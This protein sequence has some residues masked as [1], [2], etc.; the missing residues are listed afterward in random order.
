M[1]KIFK[2]TISV[3]TVILCCLGISTSVSADE[4]ISG[5]DYKNLVALLENIDGLSDEDNCMHIDAGDGKKIG[6]VTFTDGKKEKL[7]QVE[8]KNDGTSDVEESFTTLDKYAGNG[9]VC[10]RINPEFSELS[11]RS[12]E[13]ILENIKDGFRNNEKADK[14]TDEAKQMFFNELR[15]VYGDDINYIQEEIINGVQPNMFLA[16]ETFYPFRSYFSTILGIICLIIILS[17]VFSVVLDF[18]YIQIPEFRE[19]TFQASRSG[20]GGRFSFVRNRSQIERPW[21]VSYEAARASKESIESNGT[22]NG[23]I[24]YMRYRVVTWIVI[25]ICFVYLTSGMFM[26]IVNWIWD[27]TDVITKVA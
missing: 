10:M 3:F 7:Y 15:Y 21:F 2:V 13:I 11:E 25:A 27:K 9:F 17:L 12:R 6:I 18:M 22:K 1:K 14:V 16:Y 24:L 8:N 20:G 4:Y 26:H 23:L 5:N 19:R